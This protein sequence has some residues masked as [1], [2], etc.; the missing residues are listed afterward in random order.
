ME[1]YMIYPIPDF[2]ALYASVVNPWILSQYLQERDF[3]LKIIS[4]DDKQTS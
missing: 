1:T 4:K 3:F 2:G